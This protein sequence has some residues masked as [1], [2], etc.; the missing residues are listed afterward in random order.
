VTR[1]RYPLTPRT[2]SRAAQDTAPGPALWSFWS[3]PASGG[4]VP[5][6]GVRCLAGQVQ[7][8]VVMSPPLVCGAW[9]VRSS[10]WCACPLLGVRCAELGRS[11]PASG[12]HG[13]PPPGVVPVRSGQ[14]QLVVRMS[15]PFGVRCFG[16][17]CSGFGVRCS[18]LG[19]SGPAGGAHGPSFRCGGA[20]VRS[21]QVQLVVRTR[22][23][24]RA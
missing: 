3:G 21:R 19:G 11:G 14:V 16:V 20:G 13:S 10:S 5:S 9:P 17:R 6:L 1:S 2:V 22:L 7:L 23:L 18:G 15:P 24:L 4:H 8:V 12:A